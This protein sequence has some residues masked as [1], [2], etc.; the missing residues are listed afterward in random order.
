MPDGPGREGLAALERQCELLD[1]NG[2]V[3]ADRLEVE[4]HAPAIADARA[5]IFVSIL[6]YQQRHDPASVGDVGPTLTLAT[7]L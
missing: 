3:I 2:W 1:Q 5:K 6:P 4:K 7:S